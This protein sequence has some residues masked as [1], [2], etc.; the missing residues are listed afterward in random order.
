M[1]AMGVH[2]GG[3]E[4][5]G[6]ELAKVFYSVHSAIDRFRSLNYDDGTDAWINPIFIIPGSITTVDF[7]GCK[8]GHFSRKQKGVVVMIA[9]PRSAA[10]GRDTVEF[11]IA[12]LRDAVHLAAGHFTKKGVAFSEANALKMVDDL[13][14]ELRTIN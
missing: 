8:I 4:H 14:G 7:E 5:R 3:P 12:G 6:S 10:E 1:I 11:I 13:A 2:Y 9:V